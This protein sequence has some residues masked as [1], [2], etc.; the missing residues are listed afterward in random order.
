MKFSPCERGGEGG[1]KPIIGRPCARAHSPRSVAVS[2]HASILRDA[3]QKASPRGPRPPGPRAVRGAGGI[4]SRE[5]TGYRAGGFPMNP[6]TK[7]NRIETVS[8][9]NCFLELEN[10]FEEQTDLPPTRKKKVVIAAHRYSQPQ[11]SHQCFAGHLGSNSIPDLIG[12]DHRKS[13]S[14]DEAQQRKLL[15]HVYN[16]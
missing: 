14:L 9:K 1:E 4:G 11:R 16:L 7:E 15:L 6:E 12:V 8:L 2:R 13:R 10:I 3:V 5:R